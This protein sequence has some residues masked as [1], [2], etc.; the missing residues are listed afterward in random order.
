MTIT[1]HPPEELLADFATG[2]LDEAE[3]LV[4]SVHASQC[5]RCRRFVGAIELLAGRAIEDIDPVAMSSGS[6]DAVMARIEAAANVQ[7][8]PQAAALTEPEN[9]ELPEIIQSLRLGK[10]RSV[11]P[12]VSLRPILLAGSDRSRA[13]LLQSA[14][15]SRMLEHTH[16]GSE[17]TCV[18]KGSFSH[19]G[20]RYGPGDF[21]FGDESVD[22]R[23]IVGDEGPCL[24]IVAMTGD[25]RMKGFLGRLITPFVR[26]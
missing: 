15:G 11:A 19:E 9:A 17:L 2:K 8:Q 10:R 14:P 24:C 3:Q 5:E 4:V 23:P 20:G 7:K 1:H 13:F 16:T 6:F 26:L 18:L 21:D 25:L 12:G 22:H